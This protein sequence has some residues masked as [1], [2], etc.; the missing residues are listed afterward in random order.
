MKI[1]DYQVVFREFPDEITLA[2]NISNCP[3]HCKGCHSD[4][5]SQDIGEEID[6]GLILKLIAD[7]KGITCVGIMG[8]DADPGGVMELAQ[9]IQDISNEKNLRLKVGWYSGRDQLADELWREDRNNIINFDYI[10]IGHYDKKR[11]PLDNP[12][13]NQR[14]YRISKQH[15]AEM[16]DITSWFWEKP[17]F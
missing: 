5:L 17:V 9:M 7:N 2:L 16:Q 13:T 8:G 6:R 1:A 4:Y 11:G 15:N 14:M 12:N 3:C 10:K